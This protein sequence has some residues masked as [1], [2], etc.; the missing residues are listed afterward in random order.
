MVTLVTSQTFKGF[1][2]RNQHARNATKKYILVKSVIN[3]VSG[4]LT[5]DD[6]EL[7]SSSVLNVTEDDHFTLPSASQQP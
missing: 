1:L 2:P 7:N 6:D 4:V 3:V 5:D